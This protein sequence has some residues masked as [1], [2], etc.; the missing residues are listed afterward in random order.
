[1]LKAFQRYI[2]PLNEELGR[3]LYVDQSNY[4]DAYPE[5]DFPAHWTDKQGI[6]HAIVLDLEQRFELKGGEWVEVPF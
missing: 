6:T 4:A 3:M 1:M 5:P 2:E